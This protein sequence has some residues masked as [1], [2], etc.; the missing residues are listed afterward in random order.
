MLNASNHHEQLLLFSQTAVQFPLHGQASK[1][2]GNLEAL[3][4]MRR[5]KRRGDE[6]FV[7]VSL[8]EWRAKL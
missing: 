8:P 6:V 1:R 5:N 4:R 2:K 3:L 7:D